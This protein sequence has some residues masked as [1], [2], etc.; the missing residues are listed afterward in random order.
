MVLIVTDIKNMVV[1][2]DA[3]VATVGIE[4]AGWAGFMGVRAGDVVSRLYRCFVCFL[5]NHFA[6][7]DKGLADMGEVEILV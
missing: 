7:D 1:A 5:V 2:F 3:P 4:D 6:F